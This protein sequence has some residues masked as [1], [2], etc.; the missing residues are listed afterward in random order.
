MEDHAHRNNLIFK[1]IVFKINIDCGEVIKN[2]RVNILKCPNVISINWVYPLE[3][4]KD[5]VTLIVHRDID[6]ILKNT[7]RLRGTKFIVHKDSTL[8]TRKEQGVLLRLK[9][10]IIWQVGQQNIKILVD[11][12]I[13]GQGF[14]FSENKGLRCGDVAGEEKLKPMFGVAFVGFVEKWNGTYGTPGRRE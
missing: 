8:E 5:N 6:A 1:G 12:L 10:E 3:A 11:S 9:R 14:T 2:F 13:V 4:R 7:A